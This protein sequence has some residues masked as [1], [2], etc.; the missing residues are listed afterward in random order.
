VDA[1]IV[2]TDGGKFVEFQAT[3]EHQSFDDVQ[4]SRMTLLAKA[5]IAELIAIQQAAVDQA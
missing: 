1:N 2:M 3:A 5:G 4:M